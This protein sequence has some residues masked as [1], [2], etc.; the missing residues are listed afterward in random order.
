M[1]GPASLLLSHPTLRAPLVRVLPLLAAFAPE[2]FHCA[3][4]SLQVAPAAFR[5]ARSLHVPA[6][7]AASH[8]AL[9]T[10][11]EVRDC[12]D[13]SALRDAACARLK[14]D[15]APSREVEGGGAPSALVSRGGLAEQGVRGGSSSVAAEAAEAAAGRPAALAPP[16]STS[17]APAHAAGRPPGR[18]AGG[19]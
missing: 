13:A 7:A 8:D 16:P 14:L 1:R 12:A 5:C 9:L 17:P 19:L 10:T 3:A 11:V 4:R 2:A 18:A 6:R 15:A